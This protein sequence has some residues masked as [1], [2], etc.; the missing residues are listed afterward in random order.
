MRVS[1]SGSG[2]QSGYPLGLGAHGLDVLPA[3]GKRSGKRFGQFEWS[4]LQ[5]QAFPSTLSAA[6]VGTQIRRNTQIGTS[7][8]RSPSQMT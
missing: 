2:R 5:A 3:A 7:R 1:G 4:G 6:R 8:M